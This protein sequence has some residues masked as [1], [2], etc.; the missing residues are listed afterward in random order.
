MKITIVGIGYV[1]ISLAALVA[2]KH[3][4]IA[5]DIDKKK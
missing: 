4:V 1:G 5:F 3:S 2:K